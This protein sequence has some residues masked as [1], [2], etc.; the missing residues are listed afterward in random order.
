MKAEITEVLCRQLAAGDLKDDSISDKQVRG[1]RAMRQPNTST[2]SF[3]FR[4]RRK[5]DG[6]RR[7]MALGF[8]APSN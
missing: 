5:S 3:Q 4:Y 2:V 8:S 6:K 1:F 7:P